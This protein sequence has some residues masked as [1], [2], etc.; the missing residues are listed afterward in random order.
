MKS[1]LL[2]VCM[3]ATAASLPFTAFDDFSDFGVGRAGG[4][5]EGTV[6]Q[7]L[8]IN[9]GQG[10]SSHLVNTGSSV[11]VSPAPTLLLLLL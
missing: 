8:N 10:T 2:L 7:G 9:P 4:T 6:T 3:A 5:A 1:L 11:T